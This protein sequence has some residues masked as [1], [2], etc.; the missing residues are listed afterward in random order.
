MSF[1]LRKTFGPRWL[2]KS[3]I[4]REGP[5][6]QIM[7]ENHHLINVDLAISIILISEIHQ[8]TAPLLIVDRINSRG[9]KQPKK[10]LHEKALATLFTTGKELLKAFLCLNAIKWP[11]KCDKRA[12]R[13]M[14]MIRFQIAPDSITIH[15]YI[16]I[17][18]H[19]LNSSH[20]RVPFDFNDFC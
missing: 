15:E 8:R 11:I 20:D 3:S 14:Q 17:N 13:C 9:R 18:V 10:N 16:N 6:A 2:V 5:S 12:F 7:N 1:D 4:C 19:P